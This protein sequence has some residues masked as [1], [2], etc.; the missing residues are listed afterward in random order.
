MTLPMFVETHPRDELVRTERLPH[1]WCPGC[2]LGNILS[3]FTQAIINSKGTIPIDNQVVVSGIGCSG[4]FAGYVKVDSYHTTHGRAIPFATG[5][6]LANKKLNVSVISG[7]GDLM[8]IGGNHLIHA[9]RRN[10]NLNV[11]FVNNFNYGMTGGQFGATTP[12]GAITTTSAKGNYEHPFSMPYLMASAGAS[13]VARWTTLHLKQLEK[14]IENA[15]H[16]DGF[17]FIEVMSPCPKGFGR[18]NNFKTGLDQMRYF[19]SASLKSDN[20]NLK[21]ATASMKL[22]DNLPVGEFIIDN[23]PSYLKVKEATILNN[24]GR[25]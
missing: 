22:L 2:G 9:A 13:Y 10:I 8:T 6:K 15:F 14:S 19:E 12:H 20:I 16:H 4:R 17:S 24:G 11:I 7:D 25:T 23:K 3:G 5:L 1:I 18:K 21:E